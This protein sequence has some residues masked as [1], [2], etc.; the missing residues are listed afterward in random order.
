[1]TP[2]GMEA[3]MKKIL[4][5][6]FLTLLSVPV[7]AY[8]LPG[9]DI[10]IGTYSVSD[11]GW[12]VD[13]TGPRQPVVEPHVPYPDRDVGRFLLAA[14]EYAILSPSNGKSLRLPGMF[15]VDT[16]TGQVLKYHVLFGPNGQ[17]ME[18]WVP[19][20]GARPATGTP[21]PPP[22]NFFL[23]PKQGVANAIS[24]VR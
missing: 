21:S 16:K 14:G 8:L 10:R 15:L 17:F 18:G 5:S 24:E 13:E 3:T 1:M 7:A 6:V 12:V 22:N 19:T 11:G 2:R 20:V 9:F 4:C 23:R